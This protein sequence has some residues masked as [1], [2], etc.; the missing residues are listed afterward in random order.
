MVM[1]DNSGRPVKR[2]RRSSPSRTSAEESGADYFQRLPPELIEDIATYGVAD[3]VE[4]TRNLRNLELTS[5]YVRNVIAGYPAQDDGV[6]GGSPRLKRVQANIDGLRTF[7]KNIY[8]ATLAAEMPTSFGDRYKEARLANSQQ[9]VFAYKNRQAEPLKLRAEADAR[10]VDTIG[11]I[12]HLLSHDDRSDFVTKILNNKTNDFLDCAEA[13]HHMLGHLD[14]L[15]RNDRSRLIVGAIKIYEHQTIEILS[16]PNNQMA[17]EARR[18]ALDV[19]VVAEARGYLTDQN[20]HAITFLKDKLPNLDKDFDDQ[21]SIYESSIPRQVE[22][23]RLNETAQKILRFDF[24][25]DTASTTK[26]LGP[27]L[28]TMDPKIRSDI[29]NNTIDNVTKF[30]GNNQDEFH[31]EEGGREAVDFIVYAAQR[32]YLDKDQQDRLDLAASNNPQLNEDIIATKEQTAPYFIGKAT[33]ADFARLSEA[34]K[35]NYSINPELRGDERVHSLESRMINLGKM[36]AALVEASTMVRQ[37][38]DRVERLMPARELG[39][40]ERSASRGP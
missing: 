26:E 28:G 8:E 22:N 7:A 30:F 15:S 11:P 14:G 34:F 13:M 21:R 29:L 27:Y 33:A 19:L 3:A 12:L 40:R 35:Q 37:H 20:R 38:L 31:S 25:N 4:T 6:V 18:Y 16:D 24:D 5:G 36:A 39:H 23:G 2:L 32:G 10:H 1:D 9:P 17:E